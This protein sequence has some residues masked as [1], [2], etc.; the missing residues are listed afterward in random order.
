MWSRCRGDLTA[1]RMAL[2]AL[3]VTASVLAGP[4]ARAAGN[5]TGHGSGTG[6]TGSGGSHGRLLP[7]LPD[8]TPVEPSTDR[9]EFTE[10]GEILESD[11]WDW[12]L[13]LI[14][15]SVDQLAALHSHSLEAMHAEVRYGAGNG[16]ELDARVEGWNQV[17]VQQGALR[18]QVTESGYGPTTLS[19]RQRLVAGG[20]SAMSACF[21]AHLRLSGANDGPGTRATEGG[22]FV[23]LSIPLAGS[24]HL[25]A[26]VD[27]EVVSNAL[28][29]GHHLEAATSVEFSHDFGERL[30]A[31]C[32]AVSV[33]YGEAGRPW[34]GTLN[35]GFTVDPV[36]HVGITLGGSVGTRG[37][38][39]DVGCYGR[40]SVHA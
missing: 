6:G 12:D 26:M 8:G 32:E 2:C 39:R 13:S 29:S 17:A 36:P 21:G 4:T 23:P 22:V 40:L 15:G 37:Q 19:I 14:G 35:A 31:R 20:D 5:P 9:A 25:G 24:S 33:W 34:L 30:S 38:T 11:H 18:Q 3:A 10:S 16:L 7:R 1:A 27:G 28:D